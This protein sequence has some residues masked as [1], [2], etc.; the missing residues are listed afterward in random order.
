MQN[1]ISGQD[2]PFL[3]LI[4]LLGG[5]GELRIPSLGLTGHPYTP[6][7][8]KKN[9]VFFSASLIVGS[10]NTNTNSAIDDLILIV[11][12]TAPKRRNLIYSGCDSSDRNVCVQT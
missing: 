10:A 4:L 11:G 7:Q 12:K 1:I 5:M 9:V 8:K 3:L 2:L 6:L